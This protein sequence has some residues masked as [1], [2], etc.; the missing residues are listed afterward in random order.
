MY[1]NII[2][3]VSVRNEDMIS[4]TNRMVNVQLQLK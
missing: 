4:E 1:Q 2:Y 3:Y